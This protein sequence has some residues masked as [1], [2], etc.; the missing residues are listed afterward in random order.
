MNIYIGGR[1]AASEDTTTTPRSNIVTTR[2]RNRV[3]TQVTLP[4][5]VAKVEVECSTTKV[6]SLKIVPLNSEHII[7]HIL[8]K[9]IRLKKIL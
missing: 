2:V 3:V 7:F 8:H 1:D 6:L 5:Q 4:V 9:N